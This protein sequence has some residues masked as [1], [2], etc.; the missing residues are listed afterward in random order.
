M[1]TLFVS[2]L[3]LLQLTISCHGF[4]PFQSSPL[5]QHQTTG[6]R[7]RR[8]KQQYTQHALLSS[9][10]PTSTPTPVDDNTEIRADIE[11]LRE[12]ASQ[13]LD[14]L[15]ARFKE[16]E[17]RRAAAAS[18]SK[19]EVSLTKIANEFHRD[20]KELSPSS[21]SS[22]TSTST[23]TS[24]RSSPRTAAAELYP[25]PSLSS[26]SHIQTKTEIQIQTL[27]K[28]I[29]THLTTKE[30]HQK[31]HHHHHPLKLLDDTRWRMMVNVGRLPG[32]WMPKTWGASGDTIKLKVELEFTSDELYEREDFFDNKTD[33]SKVL[34][35]VNNE[36]CMAPT[37]INE[38]DTK[39]KI[40]NGGWKI[41]ER[42][43]PLQTSVLRFYFDVEEE[44]RHMGSDVYVP[45]GRVY[46]TCGYFPSKPRSGSIDSGTGTGIMSK[47]DSYQKELYRLEKL[48]YTLKDKKEDNNNEKLSTF[49]QNMKLMKQMMDVQQ[50]IDKIRHLLEEEK[51]RDPKMDTL[52][53]SQDQL[54]GLTKEGGICCKKSKG[55]GSQ[56]YHIL[57]KFVVASM[58]NRDHSDYHDALLRP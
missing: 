6:S 7:R 29:Q 24:T 49:F 43:G 39:V 1:N 35:V 22:S 57:G 45:A 52:R 40:M 25:K 4:V 55:L 36:A 14:V 26:L 51:I 16:V 12:E 58:E 19:A 2:L 8:Q 5:H 44:T 23:S 53:L 9:S 37:H 33:G 38:G 11:R 17:T 28:Q 56:E 42:A 54:V 47:K 41:V 10:T 27:T 48:F 13:R 34:R 50:D 18:A 20:M 21:S 46:G 32:T 3:L 30:E 31:I 15:N